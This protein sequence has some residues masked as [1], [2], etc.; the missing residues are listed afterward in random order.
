MAKRGGA[1]HYLRSLSKRRGEDDDEWFAMHR[2]AGVP[3][4]TELTELDHMAACKGRGGRRNRGGAR[5]G[6]AGRKKLVDISW[7]KQAF[8]SA[9][10]LGDGRRFAGIQAGE[11]RREN[12]LGGR[13]C[14]RSLV[15]AKEGH[16]VSQATVTVDGLDAFLA[17]SNALGDDTHL[18]RWLEFDVGLMTGSSR[19]ALVLSGSGQVTRCPLACPPRLPV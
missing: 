11:R 9:W 18:L 7:Y 2:A 15:I 6:A 3:L 19:S 12:P 17:G 8:S 16:A 10:A 13:G 4:P 5:L 1:I 14:L